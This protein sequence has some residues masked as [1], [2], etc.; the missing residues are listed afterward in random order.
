MK[1]LYDNLKL[2]EGDEFKTGEFDANKGWFD[3]FGKRFGFK[4]VTITGETTFVGEEAAKFPDTIKKIIKE[5]GY[6]L[7]QIFNAVESALFRG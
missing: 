6:L 3:H 7:E 1:S 2:K 5:K 4:N